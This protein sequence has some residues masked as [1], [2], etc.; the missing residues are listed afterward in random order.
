MTYIVALTPKYSKVTAVEK[1]SWIASLKFKLQT[2]PSKL[3]M[4][5]LTFATYCRHLGFLK[6]TNTRTTIRTILLR[7]IQRFRPQIDKIHPSTAKS[8]ILFHRRSSP[9]IFPGKI[10]NYHV[11]HIL[12]CDWTVELI[13]D[14]ILPG[15][16]SLLTNF[17]FAPANFWDRNYKKNRQYKF[18]LTV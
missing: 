1:S 5:K 6:I 10:W 16:L 14:K 8:F 9:Q 11:M 18:S 17:F 2:T 15:F 3:V 12:S 7:K 4:F 13:T